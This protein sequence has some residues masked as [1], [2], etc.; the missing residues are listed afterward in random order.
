VKCKARGCDFYICARGHLKVEVMTV[1]EFR[2]EHKHCVGNE[3]Q[4]GKW[5]RRRLRAKLLARLIEGKILLSFDY[6]PTQIMKNLELELGIKLSH[7][8]Y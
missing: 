7:M 3:C 6:S 1:K 4:A 5:G 2:G 8:Q